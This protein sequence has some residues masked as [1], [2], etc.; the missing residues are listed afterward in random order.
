MGKQICFFAT[1]SDLNK[2]FEEMY[3]DNII[4]MDDF[5]QKQD[6]E[7]LF[8]MVNRDFS[9]KSFS[10]SHFY[11]TKTG[12]NLFYNYYDGGKKIDQL[13]SEVIQFHS[14]TQS[15]PI[16]IDTSSV[17]NNFRKGEF[18]VIN[19]SDEYHK[20]M[21]ELMK[22]PAYINNPNHVEH[23][24]EHGRFWYTSDFYDDEGKKVRKSKELDK[25]FN[26]L[27]K[28]IKRNFKETKD[29]FAYIGPDAYEKY[30]EGVFV[31]CSGR[32][33]INV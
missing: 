8:F 15:P 19:D 21:T 20:Q 30:Q 9:G 16:I 11:I 5:G 18:V 33:I 2:L 3:L 22:N 17:D 27:S 31:P 29:K 14:C 25:L 13:K 24:F 28:F 26:G 23:G 12:V 4:F 10:E 1:P 7:K 32:N 6:K